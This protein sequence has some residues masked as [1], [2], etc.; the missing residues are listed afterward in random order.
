[1]TRNTAIKI[2][3]AIRWYQQGDALKNSLE[4]IACQ[5]CDE[6][7][8]GDVD[9]IALLIDRVNNGKKLKQ[10]KLPLPEFAI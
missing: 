2:N 7:K 9:E 4:N 1:M 5:C 6:D 8:E 3:A 10:I